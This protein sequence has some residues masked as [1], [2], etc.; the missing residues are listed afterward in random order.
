MLYK[1]FTGWNLIYVP[2]YTSK[3]CTVREKMMHPQTNIHRNI[4][5][6]CREKT[7]GNRGNQ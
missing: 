5:L 1:G 6:N 4:E 7:W 2:Y 3:N